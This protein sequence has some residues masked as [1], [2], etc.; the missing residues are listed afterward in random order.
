MILIDYRGLHTT[1]NKDIDDYFFGD[2]FMCEW[3]KA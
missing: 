2:I 3:I 1:Q